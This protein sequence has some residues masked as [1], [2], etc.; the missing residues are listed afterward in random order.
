MRAFVKHHKYSYSYVCSG[1]TRLPHLSATKPSSILQQL[2]F[3]L[4]KTYS[5]LI[6]TR[7]SRMLVSFVPIWEVPARRSVFSSSQMIRIDLRTNCAL[8]IDLESF[9]Q[10]GA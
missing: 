1:S 5:K 9:V 10:L 8:K 2:A 6:L 3:Y 7:T 4:F